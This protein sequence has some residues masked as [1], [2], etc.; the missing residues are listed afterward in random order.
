M[1]LIAAFGKQHLINE[2]LA[3][4]QLSQF[5]SQLQNKILQ[6]TYNY[7]FPLVDTDFSDNPFQFK[8]KLILIMI[9]KYSIIQQTFIT[10]YE[11]LMEYY[12]EIQESINHFSYGK[13]LIRIW[14]YQQVIIQLFWCLIQKFNI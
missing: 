2:N 9:Q 5:L 6:S 12:Y 3:A 7:I 4:F 10:C 1:K 8:K 14:K 11:D 13:T